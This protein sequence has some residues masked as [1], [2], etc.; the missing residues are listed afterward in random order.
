MV[1][2]PLPRRSLQARLHALAARLRHV[3]EE[4]GAG[5]L[6]L[7]EEDVVVDVGAEKRQAPLERVTQRQLPARPELVGSGDDRVEGRIGDKRI[8]QVARGV[9]VGAREL[10]RGGGAKPLAVGAEE[11]LVRER[12]HRQPHRRAH[13]LEAVVAVEARVLPAPVADPDVHV[14][15]APAHREGQPVGDVEGVGDIDADVLL[16]GA[17]VHRRLEGAAL[18]RAYAVAVRDKVGV[19]PALGEA[20]SVSVVGHP[21]RDLVP[22]T[23]DLSFVRELQNGA[24]VLGDGLRLAKLSLGLSREV[25]GERIAI[26]VDE[27]RRRPLA[28]PEVHDPPV[29]VE[30]QRAAGVVDAGDVHVAVLSRALVVAGERVYRDQQIVRQPLAA[31]HV[32]EVH[33]VLGLVGERVGG[34][35]VPRQQGFRGQAVAGQIVVGVVV[36]DLDVGAVRLV[37]DLAEK[38]A[39]V[40]PR[41]L[42][43]PVLVEGV[44][45]EIPVERAAE[46]AVL[47]VDGPA[48]EG[49]P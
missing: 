32:D 9:R 13:V 16:V 7:R 48:P 1:L 11:R 8:G 10:R 43:P 49:A 6:G 20:R 37:S 30:G 38:L 40:A 18:L 44:E 45:G 17:D 47:P 24:P 46:A 25:S 2:E 23:Q 28:P 21:D 22:A 42:A 35:S 41:V 31:A 14:L 29:G 27:C 39:Q 19:S 36:A 26:P 34:P 3:L 5:G 33:E 4:A 15:V 12:P